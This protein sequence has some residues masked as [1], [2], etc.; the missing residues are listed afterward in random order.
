MLGGRGGGFDSKRMQKMMNQMG[1]DMDEIDDVE[2]VVIRTGDEELVIDAPDVTK[3]DAKGQTTFQV[4][5]DA[6]SREVEGGSGGASS[7]VDEGDVELV[8]ERAGV[9]E[10]TAREALKAADGDL[11]QAISD[12]S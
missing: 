3:M 7:G 9:E 12:V 10:E 5:G 8:A 1:I 4:V 11:A 2:E 6:E